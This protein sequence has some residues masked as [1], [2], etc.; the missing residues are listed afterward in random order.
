MLSGRYRLTSKG[1]A[2]K[3][4]KVCLLLLSVIGLIGI[5]KYGS[6]AVTSAKDYRMVQKLEPLSRSNTFWSNATIALSLE[7]SV[8][9]VALSLADPAPKPF[10]DLIA[11]QRSLS[12]DFFEKAMS[13]LS[14]VE[15]FDTETEFKAKAAEYAA[16]VE[17]LRTE[18]DG[19]LGT[20]GD[21]RSETRVK[22][23]PYELK[24][25]ILQLKTLSS[26]LVFENQLKSSTVINIAGIRDAAWEMREFGGRARTYYAIATLNGASIPKSSRSLIQADSARA[27]SA[28]AKNRA[29]DP[30]FRLGQRILAVD[31]GVRESIFY[32]VSSCSG[33]V[34]QTNVGSSRR[35]RNLVPDGI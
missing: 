8:T 10:L 31:R 1:N 34:R 4:S 16:M 18:I 11:E 28:W 26:L 17:G 32:R 30:R 33:T 3:L 5:V 21:N 13:E 14:L 15:G 20:S 27:A 7:R 19:M 12:D 25:I 6:S 22:E 23:L 29:L 35:R 9:Q 2:M 24:D